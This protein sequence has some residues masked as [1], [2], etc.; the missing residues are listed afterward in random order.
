MDL[1]S[2]TVAQ[3]SI[4]VQFVVVGNLLAIASLALVAGLLLR[5]YGLS[6]WPALLFS[7][8]PGFAISALRFLTEPLSCLLLF[9][10]VLLLV[11]KKT[12]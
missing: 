7:F 10:S 6:P 12:Y 9:T 1:G 4:V 3:V 5:F 2:F 8:Y 11:N